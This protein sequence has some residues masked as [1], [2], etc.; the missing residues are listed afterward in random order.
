MCNVSTFSPDS[1]KLV[2]EAES[3]TPIIVGGMYTLICGNHDSILSEK[4]IRLEKT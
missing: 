2:F 1:I 4:N 3:F